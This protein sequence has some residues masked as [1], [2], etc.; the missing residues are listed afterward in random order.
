MQYLLVQQL[1]INNLLNY[2]IIKVI[3]INIKLLMA[4][5]N[6]IEY[7]KEQNYLYFFQK[8]ISKL[9]NLLEIQK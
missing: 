4:L 3:S 1:I 2:C 6:F 9:K 5:A 7:I 8:K